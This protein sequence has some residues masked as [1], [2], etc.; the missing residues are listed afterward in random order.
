[1]ASFNSSED[2]AITKAWLAEKLL[3]RQS[4][5]RVDSTT[6]W[7][8]VHTKF[9]QEFGNPNS[10]SVEAIHERHLVIENAILAFLEL[11]PPIFNARPFTLSFAQFVSKVC[12]L[13]Y[14]IHVVLS[15]NET[16]L[17]NASLFL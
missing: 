4:S 7:G 10:R 12:V 9:V 3:R 11:Q 14:V 15:Y 17:T 1:M 13:F 5:E 6:F 8:R 2:L 16:P